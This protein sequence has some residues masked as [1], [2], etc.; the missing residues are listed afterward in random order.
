MAK[1]LEDLNVRM[2]LAHALS[3]WEYELEHT[4]AGD[5]LLDAG[6]RLL[7]GFE[8]TTHWCEVNGIPACDCLDHERHHQAEQ[9]SP[10]GRC[11]DRTLLVVEPTTLTERHSALDYVAATT[12]INRLRYVR[13]DDDWDEVVH[14][15]AIMAVDAAL[16]LGKETHSSSCDEG[17]GHRGPC[18]AIDYETAAKVACNEYWKTYP[19]ERPMEWSPADQDL[20]MR[21]ATKVIHV[22]L[23]MP[24]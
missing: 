5:L 8:F 13:D 10:A 9:D 19:A 2:D 16:L 15:F 17:P 20:W 24:L 14:R 22:A 6:R 18:H 4:S 11:G 1:P 12:I 21:V 7:G 3:I 23:E